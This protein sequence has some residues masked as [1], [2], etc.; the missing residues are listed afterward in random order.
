MENQIT[1]RECGA[2]N[3]A[4]NKFCVGCGKSFTGE[5]KD[6]LLEVMNRIYI[7]LRSVRVMMVFFTILTVI[8]LLVTIIAA[9]TT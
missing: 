6:E 8:G 2:K 7:N 5:S 3:N 1:C 4:S 9:L